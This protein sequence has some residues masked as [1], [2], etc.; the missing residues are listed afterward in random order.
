[1]ACRLCA[2]LS[3]YVYN[4]LVGLDCLT[5]A[6][7]GGGP[8]ETMSSRL[9]RAERH[10]SRFARAACRLIGWVSGRPDHC[11]WA[12]RGDAAP[13]QAGEIVEL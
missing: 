8:H 1:M 10:G 7:L 5:N 13:D 12:I 11:R 2:G 6:V 4:V 9:G 3:Q